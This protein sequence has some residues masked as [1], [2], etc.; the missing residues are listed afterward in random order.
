MSETIYK[1]LASVVVP[2][3]VL[4]G[5]E[6]KIQFA[7]VVKGEP[8]SK[9]K[10]LWRASG[11]VPVIVQRQCEPGS[12]K[13]HGMRPSEQVRAAGGAAKAIDSIQTIGFCIGNWATAEEMPFEACAEDVGWLPGPAGGGR[14]LPP[15][16]GKTPG[17]DPKLFS[18]RSTA[19]QIMQQAQFTPEYCD[20]VVALAKQHAYAWSRHHSCKDGV[21]RAFHAGDL[22]REHFELWIGISILIAMLNVS[23][24]VQELWNWRSHRCMIH[25]WTPPAHLTAFGG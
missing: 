16:T 12:E 23:I 25:S 5:A 10:Q 9:E 4:P 22:R 21:E 8:S 15:F 6:F 14:A 3:G 18:A 17:P 7:C 11:Q 2:E 24:P 20:K 1:N 19:R 13:R